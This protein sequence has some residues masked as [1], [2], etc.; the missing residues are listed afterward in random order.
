VQ[1]DTSA[2]EPAQLP[3]V[4]DLVEAVRSGRVSA[5]ELTTDV[6]SRI[7]AREYDLRAWSHLDPDLA[8]AQ[9]RE[10]DDAPGP[11]G[12]LHGI[13]VGV[14]DIIDTADQPTAH[15]S[16]IYAGNLPARDAT[17]V[18][19]LRAAGAV[20]V[21]KTV[22]TEFALFDPG[23]TTNPHDPARTPGGS[24][25]GSAA[26]VGAGTLPLAVG[27][28]TAGSIVRPASFCGVVGAKPTI[29][30]I[31]TDGVKPCSPTLD[32]IGVFAQDVEGAALGLGVMAGD[33]ARFRPAEL[34]D[35]PRVGFCRTPWWD[36]LEPDAARLIDAAVERLAGHLELVE[37]ELPPAFEGLLEAQLSVMGT[38]ILRSLAWE[39]EQ[40]LDLL[41][42]R[43]RDELAEAQTRVAG[44]D[45]A[46]TL[47]Q[48]CQR[49]LPG[50]FDHIEVLLAPSV[51]GEAP[52][53][54]TTGDPV[55]CRPWTLLGTPTV[56]VPGLLGADR[57]PLGV[58]VVAPVGRD[59]LA[60]G[61]AI[62]LAARF[63]EPR[64]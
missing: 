45:D 46:L 52:L 3:A 13:P 7:T 26:A 57:L 48:D 47:R 62:A 61:G 35:R 54:D 34:G 17:L 4:T 23:P 59:D 44:Y 63:G 16:P 1:P 8:L 11:R 36:R 50:L 60:L 41:S 15:G 20:V 33:V 58:Q 29:G 42:P 43:L 19:R 40:H 9:A 37:V 12:P 21:G 22:T 30:A 6:L 2:A 39:R 24:S 53:I 5:V 55:L 28:Q 27:T 64:R 25:S 18:A 32:T 14:K 31:P 51:I 38:E 10:L 56:A 49:Q